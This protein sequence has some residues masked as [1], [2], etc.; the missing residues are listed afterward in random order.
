MMENF[1]KKFPS[2][3]EL[4]K[5]PLDLS[6]IV[7]VNAHLHTPYSFSAFESVEE[8]VRLAVEQH[9]SIVGINDFNTTAGY[10]SW[11]ASCLKYKA[12][13]LFNIEFIGLSKK[14]QQNN[15]RMNDPSNPGRI[16]ICGKGLTYPFK[17]EVA[18]GK[19]KGPF[20]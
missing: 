11:A 3:K 2:E 18:A 1:W 20:E 9:V 19:F 15:I 7:D 5:S 12:F 6:K 13:P 16:Y 10:S 17:L 4:R 14:H 8:A